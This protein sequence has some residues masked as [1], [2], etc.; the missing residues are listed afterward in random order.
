M[1]RHSYIDPAP[2][3]AHMQGSDGFLPGNAGHGSWEARVPTTWPRSR[4]TDRWPSSREALAA[5]N[6]LRL[7]LRA[8]SRNQD[9][10]QRG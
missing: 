1:T 9:G 2:S 6:V 3:A 5:A 10:G 7:A 4:Q 8:D